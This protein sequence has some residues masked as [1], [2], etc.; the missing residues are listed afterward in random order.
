M[1]KQR[2]GDMGLKACLL[3]WENIP[4]KT[5]MFDKYFA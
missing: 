1:V 5:Y 4:S 3:C 2:K